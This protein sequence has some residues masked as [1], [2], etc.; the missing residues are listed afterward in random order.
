[1]DHAYRRKES[2]RVTVQRYI[3]NRRTFDRIMNEYTA[4]QRKRLPWRNN[5]FVSGLYFFLNGTQDIALLHCDRVTGGMA[6][7]FLHDQAVNHQ[8]IRSLV[9]IQSPRKKHRMAVI[10]Y[11]LVGVDLVRYFTRRGDKFAQEQADFFQIDLK[12]IGRN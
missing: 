8:L 9:G 11:Y 1:M 5:A 6:R 10:E 2:P 12:G 3:N 7:A 4:G